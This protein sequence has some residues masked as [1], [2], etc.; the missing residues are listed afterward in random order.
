M[1]QNNSLS[2]FGR[3]A[4]GGIFVLAG[5]MFVLV[6]SGILRPD[7]KDI[8]APLWVIACAGLAFMLA[9][10]SVAMG[11]AWK[12]AAA[13]GSLPASAP[14]PLRIAHYRMGLGVV[15]SLAM[16]GTWIAIGSDGKVR[17]SASFFG[18][19]V[20]GL[21]PVNDAQLISFTGPPTAMA[22]G[23]NYNVSV[24]MRNSGTSTWLPSE[25]FR[26]GSENPQNNNNWAVNRVLLSA[27]VGPGAEYTFSFGITAPA[28]SGTYNFQWR[29]LK[30]GFEWFGTPTTNVAVTVTAPVPP[31]VAK[32]SSPLNGAKFFTASA[33]ATSAAVPVTG[34]A[35]AAPGA[36]IAKIELLD[37]ATVLQT[38]FAS[39]I[40]TSASFAL[41]PHALQLRTTD[42]LG[43]TGSSFA[44]ITVEAPASATSGAT[45]VPVAIE[46][47]HLGNADA[48]TL[49]GNLGVN[50]S[51]AATY[52]ID[53]VAPP[54]TAGM[55][56]AL[57]I[58][59]N[60]AGTNGPLGLGWS[61]GGLS[62]I[63]RCGKTIAQDGV[64]NRIAFET[65]DRLC[66]DGQ[67]LVLVNLPPSDA[68]YWAATAEYRTEIDS[69]TRVTTSVTTASVT[70]PPPRHRSRVAT[71][72]R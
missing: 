5:L 19:T 60:S 1:A 6:G 20:S 40:S 72:P 30:E 44:S 15:S 33:S 70:T 11:A 50:P 25:N 31:P 8:H 26:L 63:H 29:M 55:Q 46:A 65:S 67:R 3:I 59:Y 66:L 71:S 24:R 47:P 69:F 43:K 38:V 34:S 39:S 12:D 21:A 45:P 17:S 36:A 27:S 56:P 57:S 61:L 51:G 22:A 2:P 54:G 42:S 53:I 68:N 14:L 62:S 48:G 52:S 9:G 16:I 4:F 35:T 23:Q 32:L 41:G 49:P 18:V 7:P 28:T 37:G 13:D 10:A 64:N 58:N